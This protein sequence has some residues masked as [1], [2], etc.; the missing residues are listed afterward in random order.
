MRTPISPPHRRLAATLGEDLLEILHFRYPDARVHV[1]AVVVRGDPHPNMFVGTAVC[2]GRDRYVRKIG[3]S[4]SVGRAL[5][6]ARDNIDPWPVHMPPGAT[7]AGLRDI[8]RDVLRETGC[9]PK[10]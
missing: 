2:G 4:I 7:A 6:H 9:L 5:R 8:C 10:I 1:A 3:Y